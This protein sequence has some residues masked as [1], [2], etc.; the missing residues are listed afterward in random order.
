MIELRMPHNT[1]VFGRTENN[2]AIPQHCFGGGAVVKI[3]LPREKCPG[4]YFVFTLPVDIWDFLCIE[5]HSAVK[6]IAFSVE[7]ISTRK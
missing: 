5:P 7:K 1:M 6:L 3:Y 4:L 2:P